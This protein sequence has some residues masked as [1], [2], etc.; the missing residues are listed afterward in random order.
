MI[1]LFAEDYTPDVAMD[2]IAFVEAHT[3]A[4]DRDTA[5]HGCIKIGEYAV[6]AALPD[7]APVDT[8]QFE[9]FDLAMDLELDKTIE[10]DSVIGHAIGLAYKGV[11]FYCITHS[12]NRFTE[13]IGNST[14]ASDDIPVGPLLEK[15]SKLEADKQ[16]IPKE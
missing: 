9:V 15:L 11:E 2:F 4:V 8:V 13:I 14:I 16:L 10:D 3:R 12:R 6:L 5:P 7:L 1:N